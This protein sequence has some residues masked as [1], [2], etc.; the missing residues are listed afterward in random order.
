MIPAEVMR[1]GLED[2]SELL[3]PV[4]IGGTLTGCSLA[5]ISY[6]QVR[7]KH[8]P[9]TLDVD[10]FRAA[11]KRAREAKVDAL[12]LDCWCYRREG[13]Y[14]HACQ[15]L[16]GP[17]SA[18]AGSGVGGNVPAG[19]AGAS[20]WDVLTP[21]ACTDG[22]RVL[23]NRGWVPR[24][25]VAA[26]ERPAGR[27]AVSGVLK[28]GLATQHASSQPAPQLPVGCEWPLRDDDAPV[29]SRV[30]THVIGKVRG[31]RAMPPNQV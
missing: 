7:S 31:R 19:A 24:D 15:V 1:A 6:R 3:R 25:A 20:G 13:E 14:D 5:I 10:A 9:F 12:W 8:D 4:R 29:P 11:V 16:V 30:T 17:R 27:Q 26:V 22:A 23:V 28:A 18:P 2:T 21:L